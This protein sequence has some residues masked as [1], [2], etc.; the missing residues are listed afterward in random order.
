MTSPVATRI[1][2]HIAH[3]TLSRPEK[4]NALDNATL[5][6]LA[7]AIRAA[8]RDLDVRVAILDGDGPSFCSGFDLTAGESFEGVDGWRRQFSFENETFWALW[9][10]RIPVIAAV[11]GHAIGLGCDLAAVATITLA[12]ESARFSMPEVR[13]EMAPSFTILPWIGHAKKSAEFM[14]TGRSVTAAAAVEMGIATRVVPDGASRA[15]ALDLARELVKIPQES[16]AIAK[17][18][19]R[20]SVEAQGLRASIGMS[21]E[22]AA[23]CAVHE[24]PEAAEFNRILADEGARAAFSWRDA[25]FEG[26][27]A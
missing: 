19:W 3:I 17:Q 22:L 15:E 7:D 11:Q 26:E 2:G 23:L 13:F 6:A 10:A 14:L 27:R 8:D 9:D 1:D 12:E 24:S 21:T 16:L 25:H 4:R 20:T 18:Q 5:A